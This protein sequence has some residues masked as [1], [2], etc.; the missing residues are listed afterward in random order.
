MEDPHPTIHDLKSRWNGTIPLIKF[1]GSRESDDQSQRA[2][3]KSSFS[4]PLVLRRPLLI[5]S[6]RYYS[7]E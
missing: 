5:L 7:I 1:I 3:Q 6:L 4:L 2:F